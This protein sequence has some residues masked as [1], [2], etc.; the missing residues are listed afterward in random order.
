M[1]RWFNFRRLALFF[2]II[3]I[4]IASAM[5]PIHTEILWDTWGVPHIFATNAPELFQ[6]FGWAQMESHG[7]LLLHLYGQARGRAAEYWGEE[8]LASD[9][10]VWRMGIPD[11]AQKWYDA[12]NSEIRS[13]L[14]AFAQGINSYAAEHPNK[15]SDPLKV[16]LPVT[17]TDIL[18]HIQRV[19]HFTFLIAAEVSV[20]PGIKQWQAGSNAWAIAPS[21]SAT[22]NALLLTNPHLPWSD[23]FLLYEA[24]L[25]SPEIDAYG[26]TPVGM[27]LFVMAFNDYLGWAHTVNQ[28]NGWGLYELSLTKGG[29][30][31]DGEVR[32]LATEVK[33]LKVKQPDGTLRETPLSISRS[34]HG[35][36]ISQKGDRAIALKVVGLDEP[37][38]VEQYWNMARSRNLQEFE[39]A[40]KPLQIPLFTVLYGDRDGHILHL[41]NGQIPVRPVGDWDDWMH[42]MPGDTPATL[43]TKTHPYSDLPRVLDPTSGWLQ[44]ANDPPW[45]TTFPPALNP[46]DYPS[47]FSSQLMKFRAQQSVK[48]LQNNLPLTLEKLIELKFSSESELANRILKDLI[49]ATQNQ[50]SDLAKEAATVLSAWDRKTDAASQ[51]A[52]LFA[53]WAEAMNLPDSSVL[54]TP[55]SPQNPLNTP[56]GLANPTKAV[57]TLDRVARQVKDAYGTLNVAWGDVFRL[58][59]GDVDLPARG[60]SGDLGI[61]S[62]LQFTPAESGQFQAAFGDTYI[63]AIEFSDPIRAKVLLPYGNATQPGS[64]HRGDQLSLYLNRELRPVW[65]ARSEVEAHL[66][67]KSSGL[68]Q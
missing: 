57:A 25:N 16:V 66:D 5:K 10:Q 56:Q 48:L 26:C 54:A 45:T 59:L 35:P 28:H 21:Q 55:W 8:E 40:L 32:P 58:R 63:A 68:S 11:R 42:P 49:T 62:V 15:I 46:D 39:T 34:I 24:H 14:D 1:R 20:Q 64:P 41:F 65:R 23:R 7:D 30:R 31:F 19:V 38:I 17:G 44:N 53:F 37:G 61:F 33:T 3:P 12:Q 60:G 6:A 13:Y 47:Y 4:A 9:E 52:V 22:G 2:V 27:P 36:L 43:W 51:G 50:G 18:A 67:F 29:Y